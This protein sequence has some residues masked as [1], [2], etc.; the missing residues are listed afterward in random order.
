[1]RLKTTV[2]ALLLIG[3]LHVHA[4]PF[5]TQGMTSTSALPPCGSS[6]PMA[7]VNGVTID[8]APAMLNAPGPLRALGG[9]GLGG[10]DNPL[11]PG[12]SGNPFG[13]DNI[14]D[15]IDPNDPAYNPT[16][17]GDMPW[18]ILLLLPAAYAIGRRKQTSRAES[19]EE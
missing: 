13:D 14:F 4:V 9:G 10:V 2:L 5:P 19:Q 18:W 8:A 16:P 11:D 15:V 1:M 12:G 3:G 17:V 7:A 6:L